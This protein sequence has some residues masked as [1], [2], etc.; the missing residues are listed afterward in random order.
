[1]SPPAPLRVTPLK[2][3]DA[4][5]PGDPD[6]RH[7]GLKPFAPEAGPPLALLRA[8]RPPFLKS[9]YEPVATP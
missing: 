8:M 2:G 6:P 5:G 4:S 7:P 1:M 3:G 9:A